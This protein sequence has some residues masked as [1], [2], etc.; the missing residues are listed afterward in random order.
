MDTGRDDITQTSTIVIEESLCFL[1]AATTLSETF[2]GSDIDTHSTSSISGQS[3]EADIESEAESIKTV[4]PAP[5]SAIP[6]CSAL[7]TPI[8]EL[9]YQRYRTFSISSSS[10]FSSSASNSSSIRRPSRIPVLMTP[11]GKTRLPSALRNPNR[12]PE[13][14]PKRPPLKRRIA[15]AL[16]P[17]ASP[18]P[19]QTTISFPLAPH[20]TLS[21][22]STKDA[23][24]IKQAP[25]PTPARV[26]SE[27][28]LLRPSY[29]R[30]ESIDT[31]NLATPKAFRKPRRLNSAPVGSPKLER[32]SS[33]ED[34]YTSFPPLSKASTINDRY[35]IKSRVVSENR[36]NTNTSKMSL[37][38]LPFKSPFLWLGRMFSGFSLVSEPLTRPLEAALR[39][40]GGQN[41]GKKM[42]ISGLRRSR[43]DLVSTL[44][45]LSKLQDDLERHQIRMARKLRRLTTSYANDAE[46]AGIV[47][48]F[49][50]M[51]SG[52]G[53]ET[54]WALLGEVCGR[55]E[56]WERKIV[57]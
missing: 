47:R 56:T 34:I 41:A 11:I 14:L 54:D 40:S 42:T 38:R 37:L 49:A 15:F 4:I 8:L 35:S 29:T 20:L 48:A 33:L 36:T 18:R 5:P 16:P 17:P 24:G 28:I 13:D 50:A 25:K 39:K 1:K 30:Q 2:L 55:L 32:G 45:Q 26:F 12:V 9:P 27:P 3:Q 44:K 21:P 46:L 52:K 10:S 19:R 7:P 22:P 51:N 57:V 53:L 6:Q 23:T 43:E 31:S